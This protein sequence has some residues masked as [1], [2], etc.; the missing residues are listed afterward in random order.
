MGGGPESAGLRLRH[1]KQGRR[2]RGGPEWRERRMRERS[3]LDSESPKR[4][5]CAKAKL[6]SKSW[7]R[8]ASGVSEVDLRLA[9]V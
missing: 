9:R 8:Q 6:G 7:R 3:F 5:P 2:A 1:V 4:A